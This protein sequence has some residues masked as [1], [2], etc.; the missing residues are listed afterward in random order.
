MG[1][2]GW[3]GWVVLLLA[4]LAGCAGPTGQAAPPSTRPTYQ[5]PPRT[6]RPSETPLALPPATAG[7]TDVTLIGQTSLPAIQGSHAEMLPKGRYLRIRLVVVNNGRTSTTFDTTRQ[8]L[9]TVDGVAH[10]VDPQAMLIRRQPSQFDLGSGVRVEFDLYYDIPVDARPTTLRVHGGPT[11]S[12]L[13][14]DEFRDVPLT[15][16]R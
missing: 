12:D 1:R 7:P 16:P 9:V 3:S 15:A 14:G 4:T 11:L 13:R 6:V 2:R 5:L 8:Q 10:D